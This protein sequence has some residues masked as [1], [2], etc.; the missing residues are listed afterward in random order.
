MHNCDLHTP[1]RRVL[2]EL[3]QNLTCSI[4]LLPLPTWH[5]ARQPSRDA[6][7]GRT[8]IGPQATDLCV[9]HGPKQV[10]AAQAST[11][12]QKALLAGLV[13][14]HA[15]LVTM[16]SGLTPLVLLDEIA[17]HFDPVRRG[18]LFEALETLGGQ[19]WLSGADRRF[20]WLFSMSSLATRRL[21][22]RSKTSINACWPG[23]SRKSSTRPSNS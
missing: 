3:R 20:G 10:P 16:M 18:A 6:A 2:Y 14:A 12:E 17:A 7:A 8:L 9:R 1:A 19:I 15:R 21:L 11:G 4:F 5:F 23:T 22:L 13:L